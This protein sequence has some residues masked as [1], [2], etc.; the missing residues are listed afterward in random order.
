[1][2]A[3]ENLLADGNC[4]LEERLHD[5]IGHLT[6]DGQ[7]EFNLLTS[8]IAAQLSEVGKNLSAGSGGELNLG[9]FCIALQ[10]LTQH[11]GLLLRGQDLVHLEVLLDVGDKDAI[12][13]SIVDVLTSKE[14]VTL[15]VHHLLHTSVNAEQGCIESTA[16]QVED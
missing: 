4:L 11:R 13:Q 15:G 6:S 3:L 10:C 14:T 8:I 7:V 16:T 2:V 5:G 1:M 9:R 12:N